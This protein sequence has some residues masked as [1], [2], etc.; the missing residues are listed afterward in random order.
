MGEIQYED[1]NYVDA[2]YIGDEPL[3]PTCIYA[4]PKTVIVTY[5]Q[6]SCNSM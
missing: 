5:V 2:C 3:G 4:L 1:Q 6:T